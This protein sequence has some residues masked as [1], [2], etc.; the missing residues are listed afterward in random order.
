MDDSRYALRRKGPVQD[1]GKPLR[2]DD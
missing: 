2:D 1:M